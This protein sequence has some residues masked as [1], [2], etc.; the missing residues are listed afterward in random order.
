MKQFLSMS[1]INQSFFRKITNFIRNLTFCKETR[2]DDIPFHLCCFVCMVFL[3][4][5]LIDT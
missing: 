2:Q 1:K 3:A 4:L 5:F